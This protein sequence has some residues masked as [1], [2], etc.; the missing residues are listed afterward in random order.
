MAVLEDKVPEKK[1]PT[2]PVPRDKQLVDRDR[3]QI[4]REKKRSYNSKY[5][6]QKK[7]KSDKEV[8][9]K[10]AGRTADPFKPEK[11]EYIPIEECP[12]YEKFVEAESTPWRCRCQNKQNLCMKDEDNCQNLKNNIICNPD[13]CAFG[14]TICGNRMGKTYL[15]SCYP[16]KSQNEKMG[17]DLVAFELIPENVFLGQ[18]VGKLEPPYPK[19]IGKFVAEVNHRNRQT[20][21]LNKKVLFYINAKERG[22]LTRF[23]NHSC[24]PNC[25][26]DQWQV[27]GKEQIWLKTRRDINAGEPITISYGE[28][29]CDFF[30]GRKCLCE[31][32][33][34]GGVASS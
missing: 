6:A 5:W 29:F 14:K 17:T 13:N 3:V 26:F 16:K 28:N 11:P 22:N 21:E 12:D 9:E 32:C 30:D 27:E 1:H 19:R 10:W 23:A 31:H 8:A 15:T 2:E 4:Q 25:D 20:G 33:T 18:Y 7:S 34:K 24:D